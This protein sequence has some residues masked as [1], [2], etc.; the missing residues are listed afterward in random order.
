MIFIGNM[1][2]HQNTDAVLY[3][4][5][6]IYPLIKAR[7][8][9]A[10]F[11]I[12]GCEPRRS[13]RAFHGKDGIEVTGFVQD[14]WLNAKDACVAVCPIRVGA[15]VQNKLLESM[16]M[17]IPSVTT[18]VGLE[19]I[20]AVSGRHLLTADSPSDFSEQVLRLM[21]NKDLRMGISLNGL[22]LIRRKYGWETQLK[23]Y[24]DIFERI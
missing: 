20:D 7:R 16:A 19:G 11:R 1:R 13:I 22:D 18:S 6:A 2:T 17:G 14:V 9:R 3:F 23:P 10:K 8:P 24:K 15:G 21:E 4:I 12:I 5:R